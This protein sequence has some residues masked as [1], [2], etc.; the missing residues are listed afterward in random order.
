MAAFEPVIPG[1]GIYNDTVQGFEPVVPGVG[2]V[3][4]QAAAP[5]GT[6]LPAMMHLSQ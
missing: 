1:G 4:E 6:I 5:A 2:V 3:K